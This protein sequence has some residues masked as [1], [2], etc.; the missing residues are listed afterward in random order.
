MKKVGCIALF[1]IGFF[2]SSCDKQRIVDENKTIEGDAWYYKNPLPFDVII[3]D[4]NKYYNMYVNLR[5]DADYKYSNIFLM[6]HKTDANKNKSKERIEFTLADETGQWLGNGLGDVYDY[7]LP[8][9]EKI[10]FN[11]TGNYHYELEQ[12]MRDD[13]LMHIKAAGIRIEEWMSTEK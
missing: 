11:K 9:Y 12:N 10:K 7:Q 5:L 4:T 1:L 13:T 8:T 2:L 6:L 3:N